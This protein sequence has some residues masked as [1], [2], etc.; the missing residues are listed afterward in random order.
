[1]AQLRFTDHALVLKLV[2][3]SLGCGEELFLVKD[4]GVYLY[5]HSITTADGKHECAYAVGCDPRKDADWYDASVRLAGGDDFAEPLE[6]QGANGLLEAL[7]AGDRLVIRINQGFIALLTERAAT[8]PPT[9][10]AGSGRGTGSPSP[11][12][13]RN[14]NMTTTKTKATKKSKP[15]GERL[16]KEARSEIAERIARLVDAPLAVGTAIRGDGKEVTV[17]VPRDDSKDRLAG[18]KQDHEVPT[19]KEIANTP[20]PSKAT[21]AKAAKPMKEAKPRKNAKQATPKRVSALDAAAIVL[22]GAKAP[23]GAA[24]LIEEMSK[25]K[26]WTSPHGQTP[27]QTLFAALTREIKAKGKQSRFTKAARGHFSINAKLA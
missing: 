12:R 14:G 4:D 24:A 1:M 23:M 27:G 3:F 10:G 5:C 19:A 25:R 6:L 21:K 13:T 17:T 9:P 22:R 8:P 16:V 18:G 7:R 20:K 15:S 26:L 2:E 11:A